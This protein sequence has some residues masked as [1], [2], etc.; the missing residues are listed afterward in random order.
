MSDHAETDQIPQLVDHLFRHQAGQVIAMLARMLGP[1][2]LD[3]AEDVLQ[4]TL[5]KALRH[6]PYR[7]VPSNPAA[8]I[9]R[10]AKN[11]ALDLLRR[12]R[13]HE[14]PQLAE[15]AAPT[16]AI[17]ADELPDDMLRL[18]FTC[19]HPAISREARVALTLKAL[20]GFGVPEL[21]RAFLVPE[22]TIAQRLVRAKKTIR[23]QRIALE[24]PAPHELPARLDSLL[25][26]LYLLFNEG[27]GAAQG[28][29]LLRCDLCA[30]AIRLTAI[31]V[32]HPACDTP[33]VHA[34]LALFLLQ[35]ARL[36]GRT[37]AAGDLLV[38]EE[39]DRSRWDRRLIAL[40]LAALDRATSGPDL[41]T[42]HLQ[43]GIA[44]LHAVA[45]SY[46]ATDWPQIL[47]QYDALAA[48][49]P[50]PVVALNRAVVLAIVAG[51]SAGLAALEQIRTQPGMPGY[52]LLHASSCAFHQ[53]AGRPRQAL[54][55]YQ[56]A[57]ALTANAAERRFLQRKIA[58]CM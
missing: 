16:P 53:R 1:Q 57:L 2:Q 18:M 17:E 27:Y 36:P 58:E 40:G 30:E 19:C 14:Q 56:R 41:S 34:L 12:E 20:G 55:D 35:A 44:A 51:P 3:L 10:V 48:I 5:L 50:D 7:G 47:A 42:Y 21:A 11:H 4:E 23:E 43:A 32:R 6:W 33:R 9:T 46:A 22:A 45:P 28:D 15:P 38:L 37:D 52:Y 31:V 26:V 54:A 13:N 49:T 29:T 24:L 39:Q 8:W 25:D